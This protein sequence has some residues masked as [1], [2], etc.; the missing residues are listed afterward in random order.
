MDP[1]Q[2][3]DVLE[4]PTDPYVNAAYGRDGNVLGVGPH[5]G[6]EHACGIVCFC[7][8]LPLGIKLQRLNVR[9]GHGG[10]SPADLGWCRGQLLNGEAGHDEDEVTSDEAIHEADGVLGELFVLTAT[11]NRGVR[12]DPQLHGPSLPA[13]IVSRL[14]HAA[15]VLSSCLP[16]AGISRGRRPSAACRS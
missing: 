15:R 10:T 8:L 16:N 9:L 14:R 11:Q 13:V 3:D 1:L 12:V 2:V 7:K 6:C 4:V 5:L